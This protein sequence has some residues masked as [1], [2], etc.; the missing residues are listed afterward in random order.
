MVVAGGFGVA[1]VE[2]GV[3]RHLEGDVYRAL[4]PRTDADGGAQ[5][6]ARAFAADHELIC[7]HAER[8]GI[9]FQIEE[10]RI[11]VI[12]RGRVG[13]SAARAG[14]PVR[15]RPRRTF[16]RGL[17]R[18]TYGPFPSFLRCT[19]RHAAIKHPWR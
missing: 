8:C 19:R 15:A 9:C 17:P 3:E 13:G 12:E 14:I 1:V 4:V 11:A 7:S 18:G 10:R 16:S 6:A 2:H 5:P